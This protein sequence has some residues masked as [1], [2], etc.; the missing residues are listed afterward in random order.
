MTL[1]K[2]IILE[3][4]N[5]DSPVIVNAMLIHLPN[6]I[7]VLLTKI[8]REQ[9]ILTELSKEDIYNFQPAILK[10]IRRMHVS[11]NYNPFYPLLS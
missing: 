10:E 3:F 11:R 7:E 4:H 1:L 8:P 6:P 9:H 5:E 2:R